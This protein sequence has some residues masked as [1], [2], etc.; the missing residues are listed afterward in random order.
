LSAVTPDENEN[1]AYQTAIGLLKT[2]DLA[3]GRKVLEAGI[4]RWPASDR[5]HGLLGYVN[6]REKQFAAAA[7]NFLAAVALDERNTDYWSGLWL[8]LSMEPTALDRQRLFENLARA[9]AV[10]RID[11]RYAEQ[12]ASLHLQ[13]KFA[14]LEISAFTA[15]A[16]EP[17]SIDAG[18]GAL[19]K[20]LLVFLAFA[21]T[22]DE[23]LEDG[24]T[25]LRAHVLKLISASARSDVLPLASALALHCFAHEYV[26]SE[27]PDEARDIGLLID[28]VAQ[29]ISGNRVPDAAVVAI[30]A[31]YRPLHTFPWASKLPNLFAGSGA[32]SFCRLLKRQILD[33]AEEQALRADIPRL[34]SIDDDVSRAVRQQYEENPY[35]RWTRLP[36]PDRDKNLARPRKILI[37]GCGTGW[38]A[39]RVAFNYPA[40]EISACDLS[41]ASLGYAARKAKEYGAG[42]LRLFQADILKLGE[43]ATHYD[44]IFCGG[45]LHHMG[46]PVRGL[47]VLRNLLTPTGTLEL[48]IYAA[49]ARAA[50]AASVKMRE[51]L[52]LPPTLSN[53]RE[54]RRAIRA[55]PPDAPARGVVGSRDF[56]FTS[57]C[58][59]FLF[60]VQEQ[61]YTLT[62][63]ADLFARAGTRLIDVRATDAARAAF[64][65]RFPGGSPADLDLWGRI[66]A[67]GI[68]LCGSMYH[69]ALGHMPR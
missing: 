7:G 52:G 43:L 60:H 59:D 1:N 26:F 29:D 54:M 18:D 64:T 30:I 13:R 46:D 50:V 41:L 24:V 68:V 23:V 14:A 20:L 6:L 12:E 33:P 45:V 37:A 19:K 55:L 40:A 31:A 61:E 42:N 8:C 44:T 22:T 69:F 62:K 15:W 67:D 63:A 25:A 56:Y 38:H 2:Q 51:R 32:E 47:S 10:D 4:G 58:R 53:I 36:A 39:L 11:H 35:P 65:K 48:A 27:S 66:E 9:L 49:P 28:G 3:A 5:L 17:Q 57:E 34:T 21:P 16:L